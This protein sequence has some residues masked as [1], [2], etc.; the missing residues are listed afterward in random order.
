MYIC[1]ND[2]CVNFQYNKA[3]LCC[4]D[5]E[6]K[7]TCKDVCKDVNSEMCCLREEQ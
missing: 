6:H 4:S 3:N 7:A 2:E 1:N 5:C